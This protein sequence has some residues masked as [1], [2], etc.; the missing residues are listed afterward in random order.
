MAVLAVPLAV[1]EAPVAVLKSPLALLESP[2][3]VLE[4]PLAVALLP[5]AT[6]PAL[7]AVEPPATPVPAAPQTNC[8]A[9][10]VGASDRPSA[11]NAAAM[12][13][14]DPQQRRAIAAKGRVSVI[15]VSYRLLNPN[16]IYRVPVSR[17]LTGN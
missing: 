17:R 13:P 14:L 12:T 1:L 11:K 9:A 7:V 4:L 8:A 3:A 15:V 2:L 16:V 6:A 5:Q 10:G